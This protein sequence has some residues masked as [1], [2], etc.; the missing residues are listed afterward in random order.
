MGER[1]T[2]DRGGMKI[3]SGA[4]EN[5]LNG[6]RQLETDHP[7]FLYEWKL[8]LQRISTA[9]DQSGIRVSDTEGNLARL[10]RIEAAIGAYGQLYGSADRGW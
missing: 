6:R 2:F 5:L 7:Q 3:V 10:R 1:Q 8:P 4:Y 9:I